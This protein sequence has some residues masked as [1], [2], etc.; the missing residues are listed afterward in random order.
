MLNRFDEAFPIA[1]AASQRW[2][3]LTENERS[4]LALVEIAILSGDDETAAR[5][6]IASGWIGG[7]RA[8]VARLPPADQGV[9]SP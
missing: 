7:S 5:R 6:A 2:R 1:R 9:L 4:D 8:D 3:E